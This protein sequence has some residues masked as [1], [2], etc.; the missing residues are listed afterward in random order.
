MHVALDNFDGGFNIRHINLTEF[1]SQQWLVGRFNRV[2]KNIFDDLIA[3]VHGLFDQRITTQCADDIK[4]RYVGLIMFCQ[5][6]HRAGIFIGKMH[7]EAFH[8]FAG[9][10]CTKPSDNAMTKNVFFTICS[11]GKK[12]HLECAIFCFHP[13]N[14]GADAGFHLAFFNGSI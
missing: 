14:M 8:Q 10:V 12:L 6:R 2:A 1:L 3:L 7:A 9:R 5:F 4:T 11:L 13:I